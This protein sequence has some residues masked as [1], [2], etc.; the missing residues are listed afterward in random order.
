M[1]VPVAGCMR[2]FVAMFDTCSSACRHWRVPRLPGTDFGCYTMRLLDNKAA[3]QMLVDQQAI[4]RSPL[5]GAHL[6]RGAPLLGGPVGEQL[7]VHRLRQQR[8]RA[9]VNARQTPGLAVRLQTGVRCR[10][11]SGC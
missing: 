4:C 3:M 2:C 1:S 11:A 10:S 5:P 8:L 9:G 6:L 7:R